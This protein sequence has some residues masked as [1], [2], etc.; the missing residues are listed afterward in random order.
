M[1]NQEQ[2]NRELQFIKRV[3]VV[4]FLI[5]AAIIVSGGIVYGA[6]SSGWLALMGTASLLAGTAITMVLTY[7]RAE[8]RLKEFS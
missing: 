6:E 7:F 8:Q 4:E 2:E 3:V 1:E 5:I